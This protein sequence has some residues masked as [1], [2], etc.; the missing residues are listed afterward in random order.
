MEDFPPAPRVNGGLL[1]RYKDRAVTL[2][3][4]VVSSTDSAL[5]LEASVS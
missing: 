2:V 1:P 5:K 3:G 4:K